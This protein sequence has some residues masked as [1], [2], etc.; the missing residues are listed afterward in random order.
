M[1]QHRGPSYGLGVGGP[2][3]FGGPSM[4]TSEPS[5]LDTVRQYTSKIEDLLDTVS[6]PIKP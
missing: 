5:A 1:A 2:S 4:E 3:T 6:E